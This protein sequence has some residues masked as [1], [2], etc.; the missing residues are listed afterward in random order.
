MIRFIQD[1]VTGGIEFETDYLTSGQISNFI[2][3][4]IWRPTHDASIETD[5]F[6]LGNIITELPDRH[7]EINVSNQRITIGTE[8]V[9]SIL[10][11]ETPDFYDTI[12]SLT[13]I[14][15]ENGE[16]EKSERAGIHFHISLSSP[17]LGV[18]KNLLRLGLHFESLFFHLGGFGYEYRGDKNDSIYSRPYSLWGPPCVYFRDNGAQCVNLK[19]IFSSEKLENFWSL[20]GDMP[21]Q[22]QRYTPIRYQ[23]LNIYPIYPGNEHKGTVEFRVWNKTLNP[24]F[25]YCAFIACKYLLNL[26]ITCSFSELKTENVERVNSVYEDIDNEY[27]LN[28]FSSWSGLDSNIKSVLEL[29]LKRTPKPQ[30]KEGYVWTH[31]LNRLNRNFWYEGPAYSPKRINTREIRQPNY[32]DIHLLRGERR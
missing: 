13:N 7:T 9:S 3:P 28:E 16:P 12:N 23:W 31:L 6:V 11:S 14:L 2:P 20:F 22:D 27:L 5:T 19:D 29:I 18:L 32:T 26:A 24:D 21:Y 10:D 4:S 17:K 8:L 25:I 30:L 1:G 15:L